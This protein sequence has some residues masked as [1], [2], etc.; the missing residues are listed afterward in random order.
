MLGN[1]SDGARAGA[2]TSREGPS[3]ARSSYPH[4]VQRAR[5]GGGARAGSNGGSD[6]TQRP[7]TRLDDWSSD[8]FD[9]LWAE[10]TAPGDEPPPYL[11]PQPRPRRRARSKARRPVRPATRERDRRRRPAQSPLQRVSRRRRR[12]ILGLT[13]LAVAIGLLVLLVIGVIAFFRMIAAPSLDA[14][15]PKKTLLGVPALARLKFTAKGTAADLDHQ[16][17]S[18][19]GNRVTPRV[20]G[21]QLVYRPRNLGDGKHT[22]EIKATGGFLGASS[23]KSWTF[24]VD[25][26]PP[27][28]KLDKPVVSYA[29]Q[30]V[31][32]KGTI[33]ENAVLKAGPRHV[34]IKDGTWT[35]KYPVPPGSV[36]LTATDEVG[37][38]SRWRMPVTVVPRQPKE[39]IRAV[40]MSADAWASSQLRNGVLQ[41]IDEGKI[42][43]VELDLKDESGIVGW[44]APNGIIHRYGGV[45]DTYNLA[46]AIKTLHAKGVRVIGRLVAFRDPV[47]ATE[48]WNKGLKDEVIQ[49]PDGQPYTVNYGGFGNFA[50]PTVRKYNIAVAIAAAKLGVDDI[51][52]DYIRRPDGDLSSM[53]FPGLKG[54]DTEAA[55]ERSITSFLAETQRALVKYHTFL[56]AS[57]FGIAATYPEQIAQNIPM[58]APHLDYVSPMVYPSHWSNGEYDV[59]TPDTQPYDIVYRS[60]KNFVRLTKGTGARVVPWLQDF[61]LYSTYGPAQV[62][63]QIKAAKDAGA[64]E[65]LLWDPNVTYDSSALAN[66]ARMP[67]TGTATKIKLPADAPGLISLG[68]TSPVAPVTPSSGGG[69]TSPASLAPPNELGNVPVMMHHQITSDRSSPYDLTA[70]E[71]QAELHRLWK[72]GY[73]P[74]NASAFAA[75]KIDI[76]KGKRPVVMTFDD[77]SSS[78]FGLQSDATVTPDTAV[79]I[80]EAF[81]AKHPDF[82]PAGTFYVN[83][84]PF[85]LSGSSLS[86]ALKWLTTHGF[87]IGNHTLTHA[88]LSELDSTGVQKE[89]AEEASLI[90]HA[91]PGYQIK[92]MALP[93][94]V[95][96]SPNS[97]AVKGSWGGTSYGPYSVMLVGANPAPS[98]FSSQFDPTAIPRIRSAHFPWKTTQDYEFDYWQSVLEKDPGSVYV[99][100]GNPNTISFPKSDEGSLS[101][102]FRSRAKPY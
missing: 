22:F 77:G 45:Q 52:Y 46:S 6:G 47:L 98:P 44:P 90:E 38:S 84:D 65:F 10:P 92:S 81:A 93:F 26:T 37:N 48:A 3:V 72:D 12:R 35:I 100:D 17:W 39:P 85:G 64:D 69:S 75:G 102:R 97:L 95:T 88:N 5:K 80:M 9:D 71:F 1:E 8:G 51:L 23:T 13:R 70:A 66:T 43:A 99:S 58:M 34:A 19:D 83:K 18:L 61:T 49:T 31:V 87:E 54:S 27:K 11:E 59:A 60:L 63:A 79:G 28:L 82:K 74:V 56:G 68:G 30:P 57:V 67:A 76:P 91:V 55:A 4:A 24:T 40:H 94:G 33:N 62:A 14:S 16:T 41:M 15:G 73:V 21:K 7:P 50:N 32:A 2:A 25:T 89:M 42:N 101:S 36:I 78:Q 86:T 53:V 96:P 20:S 29:S